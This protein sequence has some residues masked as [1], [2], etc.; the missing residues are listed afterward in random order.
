MKLD[1]A[2]LA[3]IVD[4]IAQ[5]ESFDGAAKIC[6][7]TRRSIYNYI[8]NSRRAQAADALIVGQ[9]REVLNLPKYGHSLSITEPKLT[10]Y[11]LKWRG[12]LGWFHDF[13]QQAK[14]PWK[15]DPETSRLHRRRARGVRLSGSLPA[16]REWGSY[17]R[18]RGAAG[19]GR[20]CR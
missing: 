17:T 12:S 15:I 4:L 6:G 1:Q 2:S 3:L 7:C 18:F 14:S 13:I 20:H 16:G 8:D 9:Q 11:Y 10:P 5:G 19:N